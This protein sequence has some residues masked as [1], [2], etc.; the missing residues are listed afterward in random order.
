M[1]RCAECGVVLEHDGRLCLG[2]YQLRRWWA[3]EMKGGA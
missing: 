3:R 1:A 2:C